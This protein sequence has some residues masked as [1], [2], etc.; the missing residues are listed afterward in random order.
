MIK[1]D[2]II[3]IGDSHIGLGDGAEER[4]VAWLDRLEQTSP[5][6]LY[7]NGD[8]FHY[9]IGDR[10][11]HTG[12]GEKV[13]RSSRSHEEPGHRGLL[14]RREQGFLRSRVVR[15]AFRHEGHQP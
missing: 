10:K 15:R 5:R 3:V 1:R 12:C 2:S 8:V 13:S 7:L 4:I 14:H 11:F 6:A 9:F